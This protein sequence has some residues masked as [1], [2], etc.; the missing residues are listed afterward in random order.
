MTL[1]RIVALLV[2]CAGATRQASAQGIVCALR[3]PVVVR[4]GVLAVP[5]KAPDGTRW[6]DTIAL[7]RTDGGQ[8][9]DGVVAWVGAG[10]PSVARAWTQADEQLDVR[11]VARAGSGGVVL[12]LAE[13]PTDL[14][15]PLRLGGETIEPTWMELATPTPDATRAPMPPSDT[16]ATDRPDPAAAADWFRWWLLADSMDARP[17]QPAGDQPTRLFAL[18]RGQLWQ[19]GLDRVERRSPGVAQEIRERLTALSTER[20]GAVQ[21]RVAAWIAEAD[22]LNT[23]LG[24]LVDASRTDDQVVE[25]ALTWLRAQSPLTC[26][27]ESDDGASVRIVALNAGAEDAVVQLTWMESPAMPPLAL[28]VPAHGIGRQSVDRPPELMPDLLTRTGSPLPGTL[29]LQWNDW[30]RRVLIGPA[31]F[32]PRPP[33]FPLGVLLPSMRLADA[34]RSGL[35]PVPEP[36]RTTASLR[37]RFGRWEIFAECLRPS[38]T[39]LDELEV[40]VG[41]GDRVARVRVREQG[42]PT[43]EGAESLPPP[44]ISRGSFADRWRCV[45]ELPEA[46]CVDG[47]AKGQSSERLPAAPLRLGVA[48]SPG[49]IGTRQTSVLALPPWAPVPVLSLDPSAWWSAAKAPSKAPAD[50]P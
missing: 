10:E 15:A 5:L 36:W 35:P 16:P 28:R 46:W 12:L 7:E 9:I 37:K 6:P 48:R 40:L 13:L 47:T 42:D 44:V 31:R 11:P 21:A 18:H 34:Q 43:I 33:G 29:L 26:W 1:L 19:A 49:G 3:Q 8:S 24:V 45:I 41:Q 23:L 20:R 22:S 50:A 14:H 39:E 32:T 30:K 27:I 2:A 25:T 4:G 38:P 17:P